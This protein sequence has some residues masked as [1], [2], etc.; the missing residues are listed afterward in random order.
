VLLDSGERACRSL[1]VHLAGEPGG[2]GLV[3]LLEGD[4]VADEDRG[5]GLIRTMMSSIR[6]ED[7]RG[8]REGSWGLVI[9]GE[10]VGE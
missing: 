2:L 5:V 6:D 9:A 10:R 1:P 8:A 7:I 4:G 3:S